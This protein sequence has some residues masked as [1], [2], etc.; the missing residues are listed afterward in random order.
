MY[1]KVDTYTRVPYYKKIYIYSHY[2]DI[3]Y[4]ILSYY[5]IIV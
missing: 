3:K 4:K 5:V 2:L 1:Y